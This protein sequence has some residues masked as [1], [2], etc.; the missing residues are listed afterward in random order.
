MRHFWMKILLCSMVL[1]ATVTVFGYV[2][3]VT[4]SNVKEKVTIDLGG[5]DDVK[6]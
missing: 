2:T 5:K 6:I 4:V 3:S 1:L